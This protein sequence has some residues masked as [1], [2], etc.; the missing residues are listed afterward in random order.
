M[1]LVKK[2]QSLSDPQ[3]LSKVLTITKIVYYLLLIAIALIT[4]KNSI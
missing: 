4:F 1:K 2:K 3:E